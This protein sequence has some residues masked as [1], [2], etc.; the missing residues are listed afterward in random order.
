MSKL[1]DFETVLVAGLSQET[2]GFTFD[3]EATAQR[4]DGRRYISYR[5]PRVP[6]QPQVKFILPEKDPY[7]K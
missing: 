5:P 1:D 6:G 2:D 4:N 7:P 3:A